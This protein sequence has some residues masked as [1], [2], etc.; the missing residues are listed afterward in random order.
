MSVAFAFDVNVGVPA[1][2]FVTLCVVPAP[3]TVPKV[4]VLDP[5]ISCVTIK[6][7]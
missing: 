1:P 4:I 3:F 7:P 5:A 2:P 6:V